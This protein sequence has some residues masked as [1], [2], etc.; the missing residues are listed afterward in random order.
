MNKYLEELK[1]LAKELDG[2]TDEEILA[3]VD[4]EGLSW[5]SGDAAALEK[6]L[7]EISND[8]IKD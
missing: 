6:Y 7:M 4:G 3:L 5:F 1:K 8:S 2:M